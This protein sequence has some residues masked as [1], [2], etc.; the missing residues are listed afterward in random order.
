MSCHL[1]ELD[2]TQ[3]VVDVCGMFAS[4][5]PTGHQ[6]KVLVE[7]CLAYPADVGLFQGSGLPN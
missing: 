6:G 1:L 5:L 2:A 3:R 7:D 4:K